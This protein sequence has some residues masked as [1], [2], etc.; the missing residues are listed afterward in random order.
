MHT[1]IGRLATG[2]VLASALAACGSESETPEAQAPA[3][4][5]GTVTGEVLGGTI[6]DD[7]IPLESLTSQS[8]PLRKRTTTVTSEVSEDG[9]SVQTT[10]ETTVTTTSTSSE[11]PA[12]APPAPPT[13]PDR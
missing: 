10:V 6:S 1:M 11:P 4:Q 3:E 7:M 8:P 13:T 2:L 12:P 5:G 9:D